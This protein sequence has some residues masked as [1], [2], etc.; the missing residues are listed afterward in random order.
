VRSDADRTSNE[1]RVAPEWRDEILT[2]SA[3][4]HRRPGRSRTRTPSRPPARV[5]RLPVTKR[6]A[7]RVRVVGDQ[8][9][10]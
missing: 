5:G 9:Q 10:R 1:E 7:Q 6:P 2:R 3:A 4:V 8:H